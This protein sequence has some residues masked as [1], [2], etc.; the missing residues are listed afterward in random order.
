MGWLAHVASWCELRHAGVTLNN[1]GPFKRIL[2]F[3]P[4]FPALWT[5]SIVASEGMCKCLSFSWNESFALLCCDFR[6]CQRSVRAELSACKCDSGVSWLRLKESRVLSVCSWCLLRRYWSF[7][8]AFNIAY[9]KQQILDCAQGNKFHST[10]FCFNS[11]SVF[12]KNI[13]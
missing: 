7:N 9:G 8:V 1:N 11:F 6:L 12:L 5:V 10:S 13:N 3:F 2:G 4:N